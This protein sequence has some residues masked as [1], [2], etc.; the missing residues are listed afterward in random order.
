MNSSTA[1]VVFILVMLHLVAGIAWI[2]YKMR[3]PK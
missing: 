1:T 3:K 2:A